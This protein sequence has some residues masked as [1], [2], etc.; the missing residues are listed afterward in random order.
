MRIVALLERGSPP[1]TNPVL[2]E[3]FALLRDRGV[4]VDSLYPEEELLRLDRLRVEADLYLLKSDTELSL[5]VATALEALGA[6]VL[7][8]CDACLRAKDKVLAAATLSRAAIPAPISLVASGAPG[9]EGALASGPVIFKPYRGYHGAG[10]AVAETAAAIPPPDAYPDFAFAQ[11]YLEGARK[12]LKLFGIGDR[13]FAVRKRFSAD[14][15]V[16]A[17]QPAPLTPEAEDIALRVGKAFGL[18]LY[19]VDAAED[20]EGIRVIDVNYFPGYRGVPGAARHLAK[21]VA[22]RARQR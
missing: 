8:P 20:A 16:R 18:A 13:V 6:E 4:R 17:G 10:I 3:A 12:D 9:M 22:A 11:H 21:Y 15:F 19:G 1:R 2:A 7:N 5:S 14:S